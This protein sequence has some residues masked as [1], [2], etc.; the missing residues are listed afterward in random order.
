MSR[1]SLLILACLG[2]SAAAQDYPSRPI[3]VINAFP[4]GGAV[5]Y[6]AGAKAPPDG[7]TILLA[8]SSISIFPVSD[9][10]NGKTPPR[11]RT[12]R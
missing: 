4:P 2:L 11:R 9:R 3:T 8:L 12:S 5:G 6:A 7:Y 1:F 10:I